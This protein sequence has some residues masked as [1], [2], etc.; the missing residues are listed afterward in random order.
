M[1]QSK[2]TRYRKAHGW[3]KFGAWLPAD[4][5]RELRRLVT[6]R[7][8]SLRR[9]LEWA[10]AKAA[11]ERAPDSQGGVRKEISEEVAHALADV[12]MEKAEALERQARRVQPRYPELALEYRRE[13]GI[14]TDASVL[15]LTAL[16]E[17][18]ERVQLAEQKPPAA[19]PVSPQPAT[20]SPLRAAASQSLQALSRPSR[21]RRAVSAASA[22]GAI[23]SRSTAT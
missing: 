21:Q 2:Q 5:S 11:A 16:E 14:Y 22:A 15:M 4:E 6:K 12:A 3:T 8:S 23:P 7:H 9:F 20:P 17:I 13:A 1:A 10:I 19:P 18:R